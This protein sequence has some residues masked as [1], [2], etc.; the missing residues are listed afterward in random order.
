MGTGPQA[1]M[2][3]WQA[4][5]GENIMNETQLWEYRV[6]TLGS[7]LSGVNDQQLTETLNQWGEEGWEVISVR[8]PVN[9]NKMTI[10]AKRPLD[11]NTRRRRNRRQFEW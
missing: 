5:R 11:E 2:R 4:T 1:P 6:E 10:I 8:P 3:A 7:F 9:S